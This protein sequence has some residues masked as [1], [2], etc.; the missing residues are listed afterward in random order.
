MSTEIKYKLFWQGKSPRVRKAV[1]D[2][3]GSGKPVKE[4]ALKHSVSIVAV[5]NRSRQLER[6]Y[7]DGIINLP[8]ILASNSDKPTK[9]EKV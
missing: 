1:E 3:L 7:H 5:T 8:E 6:M 2:F 9:E 4:I